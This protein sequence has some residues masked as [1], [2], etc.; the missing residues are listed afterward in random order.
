MKKEELALEIH[1]KNELNR[2]C[3]AELTNIYPYIKEFVGKKIFTQTG[4]KSAKF[5][6]ELLGIQTKP[7]SN[8]FQNTSGYFIKRYDTLIL[9][10]KIC[11]SGGSYDDKTYYCQYHEK[12]IWIGDLN[13]DSELIKLNELDDLFITH[14]L[15]EFIDIN[16]ELIK[17]D[18]YKELKAELDK[19]LTSIKVNHD[20]L[21]YL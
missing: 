4:S 9:S 20:N 14:S 11:L 21:K 12:S 8:G 17:I 7:F 19:L 18:K 10:I 6:P 15:N 13:N 3:K 5:K 2:L 1:G 16:Q